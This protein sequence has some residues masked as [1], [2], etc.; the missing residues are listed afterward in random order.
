ML[1]DV[2]RVRELAI[3][4]RRTGLEQTL[5]RHKK[6]PGALDGV[7]GAFEFYPAVAR[8]GLDAE[9]RFK[10][11]QVAR[12]VIEKLLRDARILEMKSFSC[13]D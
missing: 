11:L 3:A 8:R 4:H 6:L 1:H 2:Q 10:R 7:G 5:Q 13:H 9:F 12:L